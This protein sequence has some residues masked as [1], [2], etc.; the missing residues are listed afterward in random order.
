MN[1]YGAMLFFRAKIRLCTRILFIEM[2][3]YMLSGDKK[4]SRFPN[5]I[6]QDGIPYHPENLMLI[7]MI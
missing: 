2:Q 3:N 1:I 6:M 5:C 7:G 4:K